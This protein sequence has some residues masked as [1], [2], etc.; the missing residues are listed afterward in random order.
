MRVLITGGA[1]AL[2]SVLS[3]FLS[4]QHEVSVVDVTRPLEASRLIHLLGMP[5]PVNANTFKF[6]LVTYYWSYVEGFLTNQDFDVVVDCAIGSADRPLGTF[7]TRAITNANLSPALAVFE[8][9]RGRKTTVIYPSSFNALYGSSHITERSLPDPVSSYGFT[10]AS[11]ELL[12]RTLA[13]EHGVRVVITR[14]GSAYGELGRTDELP[15][16]L[17]ID[18]LQ[19]KDLR[20]RS[21]HSKRLWTY[22]G[23]VLEFYKRLFDRLDELPENPITLHVA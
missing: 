8:W 20:V 13:R 11:A 12:Y 9:A 16:R 10:K 17:I 23:D 4:K 1:G 22:A 18:A 15:H 7:S 6:G 5:E 14:V 19:G 3:A 2:G 21:P